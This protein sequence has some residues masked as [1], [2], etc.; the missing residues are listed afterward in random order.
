MRYLPDS[1]RPFR[2]HRIN[3][4]V[5]FLLVF[6]SLF[7]LRGLPASAGTHGPAT[8]AATGA[9]ADWRLIGPFV[10]DV[11]ALALVPAV[12][13]RVLAGTAP[14]HPGSLAGS[15]TGSLF[16]SD[17][18]GR[19]WQR[20]P[21][22]TRSAYDIEVFPDG[23]TVWFSE[24]AA[25]WRSD[26]G[27]DTFSILL[28]AG[29]RRVF[30]IVIDPLDVSTIWL[31]GVSDPQ[32]AE[33]KLSTDGGLTFVDRS[34]PGDWPCLAAAVDGE[35]VA[36]V[37]REDSFSNSSR[38]W[39][40][41]DRGK[42]WTD[43]TL[44]LPDS[45]LRTVHRLGD[46]LFVG[47]SS[48]GDG[49]LFRSV[50]DGV[51]WTALHDES[52]PQRSV[53][54]VTTAS[55]NRLLVG[56]DG[57]GLYESTD[58]GAS[59]SFGI[60]ASDGWSVRAVVVTEDEEPLTLLGL[61]ELAAARRVGAAD[62]SVSHDGLSDLL[63]HDVAVYG[64]DPNRVAV[65]T[66]LTFGAGRGGIF[67]S[68]DGGAHWQLETAPRAN[69][70][71]VT[72]GA[73][74]SLYALALAP[75]TQAGV[76]KR[77]S[78]GSW[79][80]IGPSEAPTPRWSSLTVIQGA[81]RHLLIG[82]RA[83]SPEGHRAV[84]YRK[85]DDGSWSRVFES[86]PSSETVADIVSLG[87]GTL[88][89]RVDDQGGS[90]QS[91]YILRST[92]EGASWQPVGADLPPELTLRGLCVSAGAP[93]EPYL[94]TRGDEHAVFRSSDRGSSWWSTGPPADYSAFACDPEVPRV[95]YAT[96][97]T[98]AERGTVISADGGATF[99]PLTEGAGVPNRLI[100][101]LEVRPISGTDREHDLLMGTYGAGLWALRLPRRVLFSDGFESGDTLRWSLTQP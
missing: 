59:W 73:D 37:C 67:T 99:S 49:G 89:A 47:A 21:Q 69:Y 79:H 33:L 2:S 32:G 68:H 39:I 92:D 24:V 75:F 20:H 3:P 48:A 16:V 38:L 95:L 19:H 12:P 81:A 5:S 31:A 97:F 44:G 52:W 80:A 84:I 57:G 101:D 62:F 11:Q 18:G 78:D 46:T 14:E 28:P 83:P 27:G 15:L 91:D 93:L 82:G 63:I 96:Q 34:P 71:A 76:W 87:D 1:L 45:G 86:D 30:D 74:S 64:P 13:G 25:V 8:L 23:R 9:T 58:T 72:Y 60:G 66:E 100:L 53:Y 98:A 54:T 41:N 40:S 10:A 77:D 88:L 42:T 56:T 17:D 51:T 4:V 90:P 29:F 61:R 35:D 22:S 26:D 36:V 94:L 65:A 85:T 7:L 43:R 50:D 6:F 70:A 55:G